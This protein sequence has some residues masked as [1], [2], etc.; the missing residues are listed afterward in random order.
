[1]LTCE[2]AGAFTVLLCL[3]LIKRVFRKQTFLELLKVVAGTV[4]MNLWFLLPFLDM[5]LSDE[6]YFSHNSGNTIQSRGVLPAH[7]FYTMQAA[8]S[9]S[10]FHEEGLLETEPIG[11]GFALLLGVAIFFI[12]RRLRTTEGE[13]KKQ[14]NAA[15]VAFAVGA[16]ALVMSTSIFP[17]DA[18]QKAGK[19]TGTLVPML[20]FPTRLTVVPTACFVLVACAGAARLI[21]SE[22]RLLKSGL[23]A[24]LCGGCILFSVYQTN[25]TLMVKGGMLRLYSAQA[26]GHSA[27]LGG[28]Y[29][30]LGTD[31]NYCYHEAEPSP[32]VTVSA[33]EKENL[34]TVTELTVSEENGEYYVELPMLYYKGYRACDAETGEN[35]EVVPGSNY[36]V[37][38][39]L[40]AG[41]QGTLR[42]WYAGMWYWRLA[43]AV[44]L[45]FFAAV[46]ITR[47]REMRV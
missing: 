16:V 25:D 47:R 24:L 41:Y 2:I 21:K 5:T 20:Q 30:P 37:R 44:S 6:Y 45:I 27:I 19:I 18:I 33:Y 34:D 46:V 11:V 36:E 35:F 23:F 8:G 9:N 26:I 1:M 10:R 12:G 31:G 40:P 39:I 42:T 3:L 43:E 14:D 7:F 13:E 4:A 38:V 28:E 15:L 32:G 22:N 29:L 17:W